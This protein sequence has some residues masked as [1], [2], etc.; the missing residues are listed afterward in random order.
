MPNASAP[1]HELHLLLVD[2]HYRSVGV[3]IAVE[4]YHKTVAQRGHLMGVADARHGASG[5]NDVAEMVEQIEYFLLAE[6]I[7]VFALHTSQF[8]SNAVVHLFGRTFIYVSIPVFHG[9]LVH[10]YSGCKF[11]TVEI[12]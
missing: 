7:A 5:R 4:S 6:R 2:A 10:P 11:V 3:G 1:L 12:F 8:T 9:I